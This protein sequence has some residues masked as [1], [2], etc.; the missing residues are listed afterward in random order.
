[1]NY[2]RHGSTLGHFG[3]APKYFGYRLK[4]T[5]FDAPKSFPLELHLT[6][7]M[8]YVVLDHRQKTF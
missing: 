2:G 8:S 7:A 3:L 4:A 5:R 6:V 1:M